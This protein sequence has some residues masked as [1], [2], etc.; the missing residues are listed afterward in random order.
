MGGFTPWIFR[1]D[2]LFHC[3]HWKV[4]SQ[5]QM[6]VGLHLFR[7]LIRL[8]IG[9]L[10]HTYKWLS[11]IHLHGS[12]L[13]FWV[14]NYKQPH[15]EEHNGQMFDL[16]QC[17]LAKYFM[18]QKNGILYSFMGPSGNSG[19]GSVALT[20]VGCQWDFLGEK[21][22]HCTFQLYHYCWHTIIDLDW[23]IKEIWDW[24]PRVDQLA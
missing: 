16:M 4:C 7:N 15:K 13:A 18:G 21:N 23:F 17:K 19:V 6:K 24:G 11:H 20:S 9:D 1:K 8:G 14:P 3:Q 12:C 5:K 22:L 10:V 2:F